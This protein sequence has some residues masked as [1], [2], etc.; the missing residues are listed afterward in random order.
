M[1][2]CLGRIVCLA[3]PCV[4][5]SRPAQAQERPYFVTYDH[6]MEEPGSLGIALNPLLGTQR[7]G[8]GFLASW[9]ELEYGLN[10]WWTTELYLDGQTTRGDGTVLTGFRW[11]HR[12]R[13]LK[14]EHRVN[15]VLYVE[16]ERLNEADKTL[17]EVVGH[18]VEGD[19]ATPNADARRQ[20]KTELETK[21][22]LSSNFKGWN[23]SE[24]LIAEKNLLGGAWEFG[25]AVGIQRPLALAA[26]PKPCNVCA[27]NFSAGIE[28]F[29]GLGAVHALSFKET[30]H[31]LG[32]LLSLSLPDGWTL[33]VSPIFGLNGES[34]R[35]LLRFGASYEIPGFGRRLGRW[36]R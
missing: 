23:V 31:Y 16:L 24:N 28:I 13:A 14:L 17:L 18:D 36:F 10:G 22:I 27:E 34:H 6:Q 33:K 25:Y 12:V 29:G 11:E 26:S 21:L 30:S 1:K 3:V 20:W 2:R 19:H 5:L 8:P 15:P 9:A 7:E 32:P 4:W 35:F